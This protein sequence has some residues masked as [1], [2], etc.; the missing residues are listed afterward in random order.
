M[1]VMGIVGWKKAGKT[2]LVEG[3]VREL[4]RRGFAVSTVKHAHHAFDID[5]PGKDSYRHREAGAHEVLVAS[6][7]RWALIHEARTRGEPPLA[8]L[9]AK[10]APVDLVLVE[11]YKRHPH[12]KIE[13]VDIVDADHPLRAE[14]DDEIVAVA[15][16]RSG[17]RSR[18]PVLP[19]DDHA[20]VADFILAALGLAA[21]AGAGGG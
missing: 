13:V 2:L 6:D 11:G 21:H 8:E 3:L 10:L 20:A 9:L 16:A 15:T 19:L 17:L 18:K 14:E 1:K 7:E 5:H 12:P 4:S